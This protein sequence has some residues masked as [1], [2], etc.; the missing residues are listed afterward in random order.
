MPTH[1]IEA[2]EIKGRLWA[3][4]NFLFVA[5]VNLNTDILRAKA[6]CFA[7]LCHRLG[8]YLSVRP[9]VRLSVCLSVCHTRDLYQ[10]GAS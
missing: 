5:A 9:S 4:H 8:V 2:D 6:E 1:S 10:N 3:V 7:R